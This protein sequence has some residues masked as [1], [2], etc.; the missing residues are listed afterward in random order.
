MT[1]SI[2]L[3]DGGHAVQVLDRL[4]KMG[5]KLSLD[6]FGTGYSSLGYLRNIRFDTIKVDRS[7]VQG[8][9]KSKPES[10]RDHPRC[11][12]ACRLL[13]YHDHC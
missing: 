3:R 12:R 13:E 6:D 5:I 4:R 9:A 2:F 1:E 8:A 11:G 10:S 7:F